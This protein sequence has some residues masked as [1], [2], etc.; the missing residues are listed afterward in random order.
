MDF[1]LF[2]V[3]FINFITKSWKKTLK[4]SIIFRRHNKETL[5]CFTLL[6]V[7]SKKFFG[8]TIAKKFENGCILELLKIVF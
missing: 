1:W 4:M 2:E 6:L 3:I 5:K 7:A 8:G